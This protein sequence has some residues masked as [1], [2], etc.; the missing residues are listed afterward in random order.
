M[1]RAELRRVEAMTPHSRRT[2]LAVLGD[3]PWGT[4]L[5]HFYKTQQDLLDTLV[6]YFKA[7]LEAK[8]LCVWV[9]DEPLT[10]AKA[11]RSLR[12]EVPDTDR[13]LADH[14]MKIL[15]SEEWYLKGGAFSLERVMRMW[16]EKLEDALARGYAGL[17]VSGNTAWLERKHWDRFSEYE[18]VVNESLAQKPILALCSYPLTVCGFADALDVARSHHFAFARR[19][20]RWEV[21]Q[22]RTPPASPDLSG[23]LTT[24]EREVLLLAAEGH[25][26]QEITRR[27]SIGVRTVESHRANLMRKLRLRNQTELVRYALQRGLLPLENT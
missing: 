27:L 15:S 3:L 2:G 26:N 10:E 19:N 25:T 11:R 8:E 24:R 9:I 21:L 5:C 12:Q 17:R 1:T 16:D 4:H 14:S 22:W 18:A 6:P 13:Y 20:G 23:R 7:G